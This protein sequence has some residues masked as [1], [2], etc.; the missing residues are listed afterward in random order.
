VVVHLGGYD[1]HCSVRESQNSV[2]YEALKEQLFGSFEEASTR[3][4]L[5]VIDKTFDGENFSLKDLF[6]DER[7]K[8]GRLLLRD[9][10]D[11]SRSHY[12]RIFEESR[13]VMRLLASMKIPAPDSLRHAAEYVLTLKLEEMVGD[14]RVSDNSDLDLGEAVA[15]LVRE[16][17]MTGCTLDFSALKNAIES[18]VH[19]I[20]E[21]YRDSRDESSVESALKFLILADE[22]G[23]KL[24]LWRLQNQF[25]GL[26]NEPGEKT[27]TTRP[28][29]GEFSDKLGFSNRGV[30]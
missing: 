20:L 30:Q 29:I 2:E 12:Q 17:T 9:A 13:D 5:Q 1:F 21:S 8:I 28:L 3:E 4:L 10:L 27:E 14:L 25:W 11:R 26:L 16:A 19:S 18:T 6:K 7:R 23:L 22:L 24:D 15:S